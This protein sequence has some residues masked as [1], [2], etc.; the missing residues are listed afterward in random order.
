M[1]THFHTTHK[2]EDLSINA[3]ITAA[4]DLSPDVFLATFQ[5]ACSSIGEELIR[6]C[7]L[8]DMGS[9]T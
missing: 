5:N 3:T 8:H 2:R 1:A 4:P 9:H 6:L 7:E